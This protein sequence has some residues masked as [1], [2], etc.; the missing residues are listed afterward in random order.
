MLVGEGIHQHTLYGD[1]LIEKE[2]E[3]PSL[4][5]TKPSVLKH[6]KPDRTFGEHQSLPVECGEWSLGKQVEY[7]PFENDITQVW[8]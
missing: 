6:E 3:F 7:N 8:D 2:M 4:V 1:F 5:V